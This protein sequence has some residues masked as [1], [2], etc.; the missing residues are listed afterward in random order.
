[1][2]N[3]R[4]VEKNNPLAVH[5]LTW[6]HERGIHWIESVNLNFMM[7]K[8]LTRESFR[9]QKKVNGKWVNV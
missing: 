3:Y 9:I 8:S 6:S 7:D 4:V 2:T 5:C 1:M